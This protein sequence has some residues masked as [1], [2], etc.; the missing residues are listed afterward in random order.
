MKRTTPG[1]VDLGTVT[2][3]YNDVYKYPNL[4]RIK[5]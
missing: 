2:G 1:T 4:K 5:R 3:V